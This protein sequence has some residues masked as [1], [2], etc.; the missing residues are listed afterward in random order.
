MRIRADGIDVDVPRGWDAEIYRQREATIQSM[1]ADPGETDAPIMH[2]ANFTL[3]PSRG[4]W[5]SGAV[6]IMKSDNIF[7]ALC[8]FGPESVGKALFARQGLPRV[9]AAD[10]APH[11]LQ[12]TLPGQSGTQYFFTHANRAFCLYVV[13]GSHA[14]RHELVAE[15]NAV[16]DTLVIDP[17]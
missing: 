16:L 15:V 13:L 1:G 9:D 10:F 11:Q 14:R 12:R 4:D 17:A 7:I 6:E 5:G 8:E 2:L 3:P